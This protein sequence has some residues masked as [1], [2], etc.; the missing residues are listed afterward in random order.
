[1][2]N[3]NRRVV[4]KCFLKAGI[5]EI[6]LIESP[7][8]LIS[9]TGSIGGLF[10][11][12]GG[13]K[14]EVSAVTNHGIASGVS[15]NIAGDA[16]NKAIVEN[17]AV[18]YGVHIGDYTVENLKKTALSF[19]LNDEGTYSVSGVS[20]DG[21]PRSV[22][23][24][25]ED[26]RNAVLPLVDDI[27]EVAMTVLK[28]SPPELSAEVLRKGLFLSG[29]SSIVPGLRDYVAQAFELPVTL[30]ADH[31]NAV[32]M[33]AGKFYGDMKYLSTLLGVNLD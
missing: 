10:V 5:K 25:A 19:Y 7:L 14:T 27:I 29:G 4:E 11:D 28:N 26:L 22:L 30:L 17:I 2:T 21:A 24:T 31:E 33:G 9:Y 18:R 23:V 6:I 20:D 1:M 15:V 12:I 13:G 3:S 32:A 16:F 8:S